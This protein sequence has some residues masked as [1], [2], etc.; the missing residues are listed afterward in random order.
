[1]TEIVQWMSDFR[2]VAS[3]QA[4]S[5][6]KRPGLKYQ[7]LAGVLTGAGGNSFCGIVVAALFGQ[8]SHF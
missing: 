4:L 7:Y 6:G 2:S 5:S 1:M 8:Q 3:V